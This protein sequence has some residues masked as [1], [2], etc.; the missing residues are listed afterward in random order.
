MA[1]TLRAEDA[2]L[3]RSAFHGLLDAIESAAG[4]E[5]TLLVDEHAYPVVQWAVAAASC[6]GTGKERVMTYRHLDAGDASRQARTVRGRL[7]VV[8]DG[9]C[10]SCLRPAPLERLSAMTRHAAG[11]LV[12]DDTLAAGVCGASG[13]D[14]VVVS[15]LAK[16]YGVPLAV[17]YGPRSV[18][19]RARRQGSARTNASGPSDVDV[20]ALTALPSH[21]EL[22]SRRRRL[23]HF[24]DRTWHGARRV[25]LTPR[26]IRFP[27]VHLVGV[28]PPA[29]L[30]DALARRGIRTLVT[31]GRCTGRASLTICLRSDLTLAEVD[32]LLWALAREARRAAS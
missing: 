8:T 13:A 7:V 12:V 1:R 26:G 6:V 23:A 28:R 14:L 20:A 27:V 17:L 5:T 22:E 24:V 19:E 30:R 3:A 2:L 32:R 18:V 9:L 11:R 25:G 29:E 15:S 10:G 16:G 4:P 21:A 31:A